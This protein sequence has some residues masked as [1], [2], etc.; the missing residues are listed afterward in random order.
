MAFVR[1]LEEQG[2]AFN[3]FQC[4]LVFVSTPSDGIKLHENIAHEKFSTSKFL[5]LQ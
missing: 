1:K 4:V 3:A 5:D 2:D